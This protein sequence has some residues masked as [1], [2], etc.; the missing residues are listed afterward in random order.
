MKTVLPPA[1]SVVEIPHITLP[2]DTNTPPPLN[3]LQQ[4]SFLKRI[5]KQLDLTPAQRDQIARIMH[6]SQERNRPLWN[7]I[8]PQLHAEMKRAREEIREVL[9]PGQQKKFD[10]LLRTRPRKMEGS[11]LKPGSGR[12]QPAS[13]NVSTNTF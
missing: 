7:Q 4:P 11:L 6:D 9:N 12:Q 10:E 2:A 13:T 1:G 8:A 5:Q 3:Q